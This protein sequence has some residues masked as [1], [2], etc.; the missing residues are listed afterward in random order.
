MNESGDTR[1]LPIWVTDFDYSHPCTSIRPLPE[2]EKI[3]EQFAHSFKVCNMIW[4]I[5]DEDEAVVALIGIN[6]TDY[7]S[8]HTELF[9]VAENG[10]EEY[11]KVAL[12]N[13]CEYCFYTQNLNRVHTRII[14]DNPLTSIASELGFEEEA[15]LKSHI[16]SEGQYR[17]VVWFGRL[18]P[19]M[20][21]TSE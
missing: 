8:R 19:E 6:N 20:E 10:K 9:V 5:E 14:A 13:V 3:D 4:I 11:L 12:D 18:R 16:F 1:N 17:D 21:E 15:T 7:K 2:E